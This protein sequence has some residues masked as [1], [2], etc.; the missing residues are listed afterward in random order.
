MEIQK[1]TAVSPSSTI[2]VTQAGAKNL[3][4]LISSLQPGTTLDAVVTAKLAD[5][6]F[7]MKL[8]DGQILRAQTLAV[9]EPGQTLKLEVVKTGTVPE[10]KIIPPLQPVQQEQTAVVQALRQ[11]LPKQQNM[12]DFAVAL[13]QLATTTADMPKAVSSAI[14]NIL[15]AMPTKDGLITSEGLKQS[16]IN[17]GVFLEAKLANSIPPQGDL[18]GNLLVLAETLQKVQG[19]QSSHP[20]NINTNSNSVNT[21]INIAANPIADADIQSNPI[22]TALP[23]PEHNV[24]AEKLPENIPTIKIEADN[25]ILTKTEGAIARIVLDQLAAQP[26]S[27]E[28]QHIWQIEIPYTNGQ[29]T[30]T[31]KLKISQ[32]GNVNQA[33]EQKNWSVVLELNPPGLG[34]LTS[35]ISLVNDRIDTCFWSDQHATT[36]LVREHLTQLADAY[37]EAGLA[38]GNLNTLEG[39]AVESNDLPTSSTMPLL[40]ERI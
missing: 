11:F 2:L 26:Q 32:E 20:V 1:T 17:S 34:K 30:D 29:Y 40:D 24:P 16:I 4:A 33:V 39:A 13:R 5:N 35:R 10:L 9:L 14:N 21:S 28:Q 25:S 31:V 8:A 38:V 6:G 36:A 18:K 37:T 23:K 3:N 19:D 15:A 27:D 22:P 12:T 7:L